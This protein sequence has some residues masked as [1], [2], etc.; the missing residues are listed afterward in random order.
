[1]APESVTHL[2]DTPVLPSEPGLGIRPDLEPAAPGRGRAVAG[3]TTA[4]DAPDLPGTR[5]PAGVTGTS[6]PRGAAGPERQSD[7]TES[8]GARR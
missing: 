4:G 8:D 7:P 5:G 2:V 1:V 3:R 6:E